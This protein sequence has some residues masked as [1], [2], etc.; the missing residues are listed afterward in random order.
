M[1]AAVQAADTARSALQQ[2]HLEHGEVEAAQQQ[3]LLAAETTV[4]GLRKDLTQ[5]QQRADDAEHRSGEEAGQGAAAAA[6]ASAM[7]EQTE[8][9]RAQMCDD[10][11]RATERHTTALVAHAEYE[12]ATRQE[13]QKLRVRCAELEASL[14]QLQPPLLSTLS[15]PDAA[16]ASSSASEQQFPKGEES[17]DLRTR[18]SQEVVEENRRLRAEVK[19]LWRKVEEESSRVR[20][21]V[22]REFKRTGGTL[23]RHDKPDLGGKLRGLSAKLKSAEERSAMLEG[24]VSTERAIAEELRAK[25]RARSPVKA[26][27]VESPAKPNGSAGGGDRA[28][29]RATVRTEMLEA[30]NARLRQLLGAARSHA[31]QLA[32]IE[33]EAEEARAEAGSLRDEK[34]EL[35]R[36]L[37]SALSRLRVCEHLFA[38]DHDARA[39]GRPEGHAVH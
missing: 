26:Q 32:G 22:E 14:Q 7:Q 18:D 5:L 21:A 15:T 27:R 4:G 30:E 25:L 9:L 29:N 31:Q 12:A 24:A 38:E 1:E 16:A 37:E 20:A 10:A 3:Q 11:A 2:A 17:P 33:F 39:H 36:Q 35:S 23:L 6:A 28:L 8:A 13:A 34:T 19:G